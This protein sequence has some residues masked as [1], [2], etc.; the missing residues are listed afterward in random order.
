ME[1][2]NTQNRHIGWWEKSTSEPMTGKN[3]ISQAISN[4]KEPI[5]VISKN[6][7]LSV[8]QNGI[9][10]IGIKE[11]DKDEGFPL[12]A[13]APPLH[14]EDLGDP[15]FKKRYNLRYAYI[16]G[17]MAN[18]ITSTEM[19]EAAGRSG[20]L[21]FFGSG[22]LSIDEIE[23]KIHDLKQRLD[24]FPFGLNLIHSH[25]SPEFEMETVNLYLKHQINLIS[26]SAYLEL[27]LP[28][29]FFRIKGIHRN[30]QGEIVCPN[31]I[32]AKVSR[33]E[34]ASKFLSPPPEKLISQLI[35]NKMISQE[36][37]SFAEHISMADD[38]TA[39]ADSG[40]HTDNR[41]AISLLPTMISLRNE[42]TSTYNYSKPIGVGLGGGIATPEAAAAA[43]ALGA[44][45]VLT[46]SINQSCIEAGTSET[47]RQMLAQAKQADVVMAPSGD[48]F[49]MGVKVQVLKRGTMFP[50]L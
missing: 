21:G 47:V 45:Y 43:F 46:G 35:E 12:L 10:R 6:G 22:G 26:A 24:T 32:I 48:M 9:A 34:V 33:I 8:A 38:I 4:I 25:Q 15:L 19:V 2:S 28:L 36:E 29:V 3:G 40:G 49:E 13:Y 16:V 20:M 39:E 41:P 1:S 23:N 44:S 50:M 7:D 5:Y 30:A 11:T 27:T 37:A 17:A 14:P 31:R 18:G 42:L